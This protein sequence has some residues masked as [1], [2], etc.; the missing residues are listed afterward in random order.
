MQ[1]LQGQITQ[2]ERK[3]E[4]LFLVAIYHFNMMYPFVI[5]YLHIRYGSGFMVSNSNFN[6]G[7]IFHNLESGSVVIFVIDTLS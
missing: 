1:I 5:I 3:R 6:Q 7:K 2:K 4:L